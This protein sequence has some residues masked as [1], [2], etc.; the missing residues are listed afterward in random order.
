VEGADHGKCMEH[1]PRRGPGGKTQCSPVALLLQMDQDTKLAEA[2]DVLL[3][4]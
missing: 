2:E 4:L 3:N 1:K